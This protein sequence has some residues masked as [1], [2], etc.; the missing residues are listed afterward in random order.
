MGTLPFLLIIS[1][2]VPSKNG[3]GISQTLYNLF[4]AYPTENVAIL[5]D[6]KEIMDRHENLLSSNILKARI[7]FFSFLKNRIGNTINPFISF[8]NRSIRELGYLD[9]D[10]LRQYSNTQINIILST[11]DIDKVHYTVCLVRKFSFLLIT[12]YMDDWMNN[13]NT[14]WLG[15]NVQNIIRQS[16]HEACGLLFIS[17]ALKIEL[18]QRYYW[19]QKP[20]LIV[21]NPVELYQDH[22]PEPLMG[23]QIVYA[24]SIWP[25]H[26][27]ALLL[28]AKAVSFLRKK[29]KAVQLTIY[30]KV[31][32]W[33]Q[34]KGDLAL[35]GIQYGGFIAYDAIPETLQQANILLV[36]ASFDKKFASYSA[37]SVQTKLTDYMNAGRAIL[38]IGPPHSA[39]NDFVQLWNIGWVDETMDIIK[40]ATTIE[41]IMES[42]EQRLQYALNGRN[43]ILHY[44]S[45][46]IV[47]G[48]LYHFINSLT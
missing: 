19:T 28:A 29:G 36:T 23:F 47:Q 13:V 1:D 42:T 39:S 37:S 38:S 17:E 33:E 24:G 22:V 48:K 12:Y 30:T 31:F 2:S 43:A 32:F 18:K 11:T 21:H 15:N 27:N 5:V 41:T 46:P 7:N 8:V 9:A 16:L 40:L 45:K 34:Y 6:K 10:E 44:F 25:M 4:K 26:F 20:D 3:G 14:K 35:D